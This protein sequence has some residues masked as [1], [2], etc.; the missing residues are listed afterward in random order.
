MII[1]AHMHVD[2]IPALGWKME[3]EL[4]VRPARRGRHR[5]GRRHDDRRRARGQPGRDRAR[6]PRRAEYPDRLWAFARI[7][8]WYGDDVVGAARARLRSRVQGSQAPSGVDDRAP[9]GEDTLRLIR[10]AVAHSAPTLFHCGDE[11]L[12]TPLAVAR[13]R[14]RRSRGDDHPRT[15]GRVLP[16]RRG[17]RGR[18][19]RPEPRARDVGDAIPGEDQRGGRA[20]RPRRGSSTAATGRSAR[21]GSRSRRC[22][23]R[24]SSRMPSASSSARTPC[25]ILDAVR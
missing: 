13:G 1:D 15:H 8:P 12:T 14:C 21:R 2:D 16:R 6:R 4:C 20:P 22:G 25:R 9:S 11:P 24:A 3:A 19:A 5:P 17:D 7:H 23:S 10:Q 18:G